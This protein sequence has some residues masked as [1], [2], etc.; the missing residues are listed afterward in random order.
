MTEVTYVLRSPVPFAW[1][2]PP[3]ERMQWPVD[4]EMAEAILYSLEVEDQVNCVMLE[5][6][7]FYTAWAVVEGV[8][9]NLL[10]LMVKKNSLFNKPCVIVVQGVPDLLPAAPA[11]EVISKLS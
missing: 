10:S 6:G 7:H 3:G 2:K 11:Q 8:H 9:G 4:Q 5:Q 1:H